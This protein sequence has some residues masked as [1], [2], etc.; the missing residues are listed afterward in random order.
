MLALRRA[1]ASTMHPANSP[2]LTAPLRFDLAVQRGALWALSRE[3][4]SSV[5]K[6]SCFSFQASR[7]RGGP[8]RSGAS[9]GA[10]STDTIAGSDQS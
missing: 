1:A 3:L 10:P 4:T 2:T 5:A 6:M 8:R 9:P 7:I